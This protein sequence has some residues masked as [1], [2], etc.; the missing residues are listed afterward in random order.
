MRSGA[1]VTLAAASLV[2]G[3]A[4]AQT[5]SNPARTALGVFAEVCLNTSANHA[6][7]AEAA[8]A[9][10]F[11]P[12]TSADVPQ[13]RRRSS[14]DLQVHIEGREQVDSLVLTGVVDGVPMVVQLYTRERTADGATNRYPACELYALG[15]TEADAALLFPE[16]R[17]RD[18]FRAAP[19]AFTTVNSRRFTLATSWIALES[20]HSAHRTL[21]FF[22]H[23]GP[24]IENA[25]AE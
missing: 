10:A 16:G 18:A 15:V 4:S 8:E 23:E 25:G 3:A 9:R 21:A 1:W 17:Q 5:P 2:F 12:G 7:A 22:S 6:A 13:T 20:A 14:S 11:A 19:F 24:A